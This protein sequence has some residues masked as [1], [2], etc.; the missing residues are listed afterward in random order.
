MCTYLEAIGSLSRHNVTERA[1]SEPRWRRAQNSVLSTAGEKGRESE[2]GVE[3]AG[4]QVACTAGGTQSD[5][6]PEQA[7]CRSQQSMRPASPKAEP[8]QQ[9]H[10]GMYFPARRAMA[11]TVFIL[12]RSP[13]AERVCCQDCL[14]V[15]QAASALAERFCRTKSVQVPH[16]GDCVSLVRRDNRVKT[17][18]MF[19]NTA[20]NMRTP[21]LSTASRMC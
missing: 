2:R 8:C 7:E 12:Q 9:K 4:G 16:H 13:I 5:C 19:D 17:H 3:S 18:G 14:F 6:E 11:P 20:Q 1:T 21:L 15:C 10:C